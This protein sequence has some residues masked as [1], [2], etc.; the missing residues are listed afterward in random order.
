MK[1][2]DPSLHAC[3]QLLF[4]LILTVTIGNLLL[5]C[6]KKRNELVRFH[7]KKVWDQIVWNWILMVVIV[8]FPPGVNESVATSSCHL[9]RPP[10][11]HKTRETRF[12]QGTLIK[13]KGAR[14]SFAEAKGRDH[15]NLIQAYKT[16]LCRH[17]RVASGVKIDLNNTRVRG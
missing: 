14:R 12:D 3:G 17:R 8:S 10:S 13:F 11:Q 4:S 1:P 5:L 6:K 16:S 2:G 15:L 7:T 9:C